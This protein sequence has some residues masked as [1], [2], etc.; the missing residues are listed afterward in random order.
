MSAADTKRCGFAAVV[1]LPNAGKSTLVNA[2]VGEK[3][4][5]VSRKIQTTRM[6]VLGIATHEG[7]QLILIDTPGIFKPKKRLDKAMVGAAFEALNE[8]DI[9]V[10]LVDAGLKN[11][12]QANERLIKALPENV[13]VI[14]TLNKVDKVR[15]KDLLALAAGFNDRFPYAE[16]YMIS[17]LKKDGTEAFIEGLAAVL[18]EGEW[19]FSPDQITDMPMRIM[20][21]EIT[22]EKVFDRLHEELPYVALVDT[23]NW[24]E[25]DD[26]SVKISQKISVLKDSQKGIVLGK[27]GGRIKEIGTAARKELEKLL[28]RRVHLKLF[29]KVQDKQSERR[30]HFRA[31]GLDV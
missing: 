9:A 13:P 28:E 3:I 8:A 23:E 4:S 20:A 12:L 2:L 10:H 25:L 30:A 27:G 21:A 15:K 6:R 7:A 26:G 29:V 14:L 16:T 18:P 1:G 24:E 5:I 11:T 31:L 22:R 17:A 19:I